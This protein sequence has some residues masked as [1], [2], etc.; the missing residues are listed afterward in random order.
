MICSWLAS[1]VECKLKA[2]DFHRKSRICNE[3]NRFTQIEGTYDELN[4]ITDDLPSDYQNKNE[5]E[6]IDDEIPMYWFDYDQQQPDGFENAEEQEQFNL[7]LEQSQIEHS[8][9][10]TLR[11]TRA[12]PY[13]QETDKEI[14]MR[15]QQEMNTEVENSDAKL[16]CELR[17][18][19]SARIKKFKNRNIVR[20]DARIATERTCEAMESKIKTEFETKIANLQNKNAKNYENL[21]SESDLEDM[22]FSD[23]SNNEIE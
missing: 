23:F 8:M 2:V 9:I 5:R 19:E 13:Q 6:T 10:E 12:N 17:D 18:K 1:L 14:A 20:S 7:A 3:N 16:A 21:P 15:L 11:K 4:I 22:D